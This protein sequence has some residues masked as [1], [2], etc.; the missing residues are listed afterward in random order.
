[1]EVEPVAIRG[2]RFGLTRE[3]WRDTDD[4]DRP[5][6]V[7]SLTLT[8][9]N[10]DELVYYTVVFDPDDIK[11]AIDE[12]TARWVA[13]GEVAHPEVIEAARQSNEAYNRHDWDAIAAIE[14]D[15]IYV[16]H[17]QLATEH[18]ETIEDH[19]VS[20]RTVASLIP[21]MWVE[22]A[23]I[24][25]HSAAAIVSEVVVKGTT[26]EGAAIEL[27]A[28]ILIVFDGVQVMRMEAFDPGQR[29]MALARFDEIN[30]PTPHLDNA[31]TRARAR[32]AHA[33]NDRDMGGFRSLHDPDGLYD[34]RRKGLRDSGKA[35]PKV[36]RAVLE[37][38]K[39]WRME[40]EPIAVRGAFLGLTRERW[41]DTSE[42]D[43]PITA[44][45][46][47]LTEASD[48]G[49]I[50]HTTLFDPEDVDDAFRELTARWIA[51]GEVAHPE[52]IEAHLKILQQ[53]NRHDWEAW[54][55]SLA[56][57]THI[58][59][60]QLGAGETV[61]D[62]ITSATTAASLIPNV[63]IE[64]VEILRHSAV[65]VVGPVLAKGT[66]S[67]GVE[68]EIPMLLLGQFDGDRLTHFEVFDPDQHD[69][70]LA[71]FDELNQR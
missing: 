51:S 38:P 22:P 17:R 14:A 65:G 31:A 27:P 43:R 52:V 20:I 68:V 29:G 57:A 60:R 25:A 32:L 71:R 2:D 39:G 50:C 62:F 28:I 58:N 1:M 34:D 63:W 18:P 36:M 42:V 23:E 48:N 10:S 54:A 8:E 15:A 30:A 55:S 19:W 59:H 21:D 9:V 41:R 66:S 24:I 12:L 70:A 11:G 3:R 44:E 7:E 45:T 56:G 61:A 6:T 13:S 49:L 67:Q 33:F 40:I 5:V 4:A 53:L 35:E 64:P 26:A 47:M 69:M 16:N 46:L 37:A